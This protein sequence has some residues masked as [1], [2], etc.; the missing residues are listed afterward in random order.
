[1]ILTI[2]RCIVPLDESV[3]PL[4]KPAIIDLTVRVDFL[5]MRFSNDFYL[6]FSG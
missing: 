6:S 1:M 3:F 2:S 5:L 4:D